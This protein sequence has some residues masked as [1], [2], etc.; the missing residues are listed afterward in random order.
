MFQRTLLFSLLWFFVFLLPVDTDAGESISSSDSQWSIES[1]MRGMAA[2]KQ[3][4]AKYTEKQY[5][6]VL[7]R[8]LVSSGRLS[9]VAPSTLEKL[10]EQ[11]VRIS[12]RAEGD[13]FIIK[14]QNKRPR[15]VLLSDYPV[16]WAFI[17]SLRATLRGDLKVLNSF[18]SIK[19]EGGRAG[20]SLDLRPRDNEM[21]SIIQSIRL[22][23]VDADLNR[24]EIHEVEGDRSLMSI[25]SDP[26]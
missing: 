23:G 25:E 8:P 22:S 18:Y 12:Y 6:A 11:P 14:K 4:T 21:S 2:V 15:V 9:F 17:E 20:W 7:T 24:V 3:R 5:A 26:S 10:T 19:L 1:L 13:N 16:L